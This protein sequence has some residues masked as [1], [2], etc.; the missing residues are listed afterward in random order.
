MGSTAVIRTM[1][2]LARNAVL[3][4]QQEESAC[5]YRKGLKL[6]DAANWIVEVG[7]KFDREPFDLRCMLELP[8]LTMS[9]AQTCHRCR[10]RLARARTRRSCKSA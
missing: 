8:W 3:Q 5:D 1:P 6:L 10:R 2:E 4:A 9:L 7:W